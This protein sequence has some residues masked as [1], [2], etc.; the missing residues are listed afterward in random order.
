M[1]R[2]TTRKEFERASMDFDRSLDALEKAR[3]RQDRS[4]NP[5]GRLVAGVLVKYRTMGVEDSGQ[6][7]NLVSELY[8]YEQR[9][10]PVDPEV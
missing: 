9:M 5:V 7:L 6:H 10:Q 3:Q 1:E 2:F 4:G 8:E